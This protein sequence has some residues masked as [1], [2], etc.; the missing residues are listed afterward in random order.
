MDGTPVLFPRNGQTALDIPD[1]VD[2]GGDDLCIVAGA[3][4]W[5]VDVVDITGKLVHMVAVLW[6]TPA[7]GGL[8]SRIV[9][10]V[11]FGE[12]AEPVKGLHETPIRIHHRGEQLDLTWK[13]D[14]AATE[15]VRHD[16]GP[17]IMSFFGENRE[18]Q[19]TADDDGSQ[20]M[21]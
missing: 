14:H 18:H 1:V 7:R 12:L 5:A 13:Q 4:E 17:A 3:V 10:R 6:T 15:S 20:W 8:D 11:A 9:V 16:C 19:F 2:P 21:F